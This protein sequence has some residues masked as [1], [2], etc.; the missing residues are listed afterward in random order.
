MLSCS[1]PVLVPNPALACRMGAGTAVPSFPGACMEQLCW[2]KSTGE[3]LDTPETLPKEEPVRQ[4][5]HWDGRGEKMEEI[6]AR[7]D[8]YLWLL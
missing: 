3:A 2:G 7:K 1:L 4:R 8:N 5:S 6:I